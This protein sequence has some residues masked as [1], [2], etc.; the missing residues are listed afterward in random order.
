MVERIPDTGED[1][2]LKDDLDL[3]DVKS[4]SH[5]VSSISFGGELI[6]SITIENAR[7]LAR[8]ETASFSLK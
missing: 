1:H 4:F 3:T 7:N 5:F 2:N 8:Y 6:A